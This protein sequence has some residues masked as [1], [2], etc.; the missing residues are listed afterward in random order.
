MIRAERNNSKVSTLEV[1]DWVCRLFN[2]QL[3]VFFRATLNINSS[4]SHYKKMRTLN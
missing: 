2:S 1:Y 4:K 3:Q